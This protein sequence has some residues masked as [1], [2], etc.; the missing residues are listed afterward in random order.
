MTLEEFT[1]LI[2]KLDLY[3][4][5][6]LYKDI[7]YGGIQERL[8]YYDNKIRKDQFVCVPALFTE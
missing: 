8:S 2:A 5:T 6:T 4:S 7:R 1:A 3:Q